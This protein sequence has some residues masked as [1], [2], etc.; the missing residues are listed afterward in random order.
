VLRNVIENALS[1]SPKDGTIRIQ[2]R[3]SAGR[4]I[5]T[6]RDEGPGIPEENLEVIF[7]RFYTSRPQSHGF[8][9]NSGLG[10]SISRQI[11]DVHDGEINASNVCDASG[12]ITGAQFEISLPL[13]LT[14]KQ[15]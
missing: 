2:A 12:A 5:I 11:I 13:A 6:I 7:R 4:A 8:G 3:A 1:F 9:R 14:A 10:L 15:P